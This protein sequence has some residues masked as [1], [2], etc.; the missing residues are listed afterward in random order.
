[1][2]GVAVVLIVVCV[3]ASFQTTAAPTH[4]TPIVLPTVPMKRAAKM[5]RVVSNELE[6]AADAPDF[7]KHLISRAEA[8]FDENSKNID[9]PGPDVITRPVARLAI[10]PIVKSLL[11]YA[12]NHREEPNEY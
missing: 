4:S 2:R 8:V 10:K 6:F 7:E 11:R 1:M 3:A 5:L 9:F 12:Q